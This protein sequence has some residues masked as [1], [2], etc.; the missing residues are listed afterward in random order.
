MRQDLWHQWTQANR[1]YVSIGLRKCDASASVVC[2][3]QDFVSVPLHGR[4]RSKPFYHCDVGL[5]SRARYD[6]AQITYIMRVELRTYHF[7]E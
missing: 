7:L 2:G 6:S 4:A 3:M 1:R 5:F